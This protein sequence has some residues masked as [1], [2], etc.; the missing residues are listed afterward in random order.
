GLFFR[1]HTM[2]ELFAGAVQRGITLYPVYSPKDVVEDI[3]L[4]DRRFWE[5]LEHPELGDT[6]TYPGA[7]LKLSGSECGLR[8]RAPLIGEHN[9]EIYGELR[10]NVSQ[11]ADN[12]GKSAR[13]TPQGQRAL[14]KHV[15]EGLKVLDFCW[16]AAG[17]T[18][19]KLLVDHGATVIRVESSHR[20][21]T[22]RLASP[23]KDSLPGIN[24]SGY[25]ASFN[26][27]KLSLALNLQQPKAIEI[28][29]KLVGWADIVA[30]SY[31]P[32]AMS[33][34]GLD[35]ESLLRIKPDLIM[36]STSQ[37]GQTGPH[38]GIAGYGTQLVS[39]AGF[40]WLGGWP[41]RVPVGPQGAYTDTTA[42]AVGATAI[43]AALDY[44]RRTG[45]GM[46]IDL[47][48]YESA[49]NFIAPVL[50][51]YMVNGRI[52]HAQGNRCPEA[53]P[54]GVFHCKGEERWCNIAVFNEEEWLA[55]RGE[56]GNPDWAG[57]PEFASFDLRK[58]NED[59]LEKQIA[60][61]TADQ[62]A[63]EVML[64]LQGAGVP[65]G[66]V[67]N[68]EDLHN[69]P[70]LAHRNFLRVLDHSEI[71]KHSYEAL[72]FKLSK[73]PAE[74]KKAA[75]CLGDDTEYVCT[76]I[77]GLSDE[78]VVQLIADGVLE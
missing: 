35:Y 57:K 36:F 40:T 33:R 76:Q 70:Q 75:P 34:M 49:A 48:H 71:G 23:F 78:E 42:P 65:A 58:L 77:L 13:A 74:L 22:L 10:R 9:E 39:L 72:P 1:Q 5:T 55:L 7:F 60:I 18:T 73:T 24:R 29:R 3:Q 53:A 27:D 31:S 64:R 47:S 15:F 68:S 37:Q 69:D 63:E 52:Q 44:K 32:G 45:K 16:V 61:W 50:L 19:T 62:I 4:K 2:V 56:M 54:H 6:I 11:G 26:N 38:A 8:R 66:V 43:A 41:D 51:D 20:P 12:P 25:Y 46:H 17:P 21:D 59:E 67:Q 14:S 30:E 28:A